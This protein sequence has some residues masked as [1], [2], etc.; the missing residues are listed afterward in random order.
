MYAG[1]LQTEDQDFGQTYT[2]T[3]LSNGNGNFEVRGNKLYITKSANLNYEIKT[4]YHLSVRST[5][6]GNPQ[7]SIENTLIMYLKDLNEAPTDITLSNA[8]VVENT[9]TG[10]LIGKLSITDP[11]NLGPQ[12]SHQSHTCRLTDSANGMIGISMSNNENQLTVGTA[13][14]NFEAKSIVGI[15]VEC[16]DPNG[17]L[18]QK[19]FNITV[20]DVNEAPNKIV[21]SNLN[22]KENQVIYI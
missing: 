4:S 2:Y 10:T 14:V 5:D 17:L 16:T 22:V 3:L 1:E 19:A 12:G 18:V 11:D 20:L 7:Y 13:G 15:V 21:I 8:T 9:P 6:S